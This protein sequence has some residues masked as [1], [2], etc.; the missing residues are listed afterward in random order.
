[1]SERGAVR[2]LGTKHPLGLALPAMFQDDSFVQRMCEGLDEVL[3]PVPAT[4][5]SFWAY[6]DPRLCPED[7]VDWLGSWLG[8]EPDQ[9]WSVERRRAL[10]ESAADLSRSVGTAAGLAD[11]I[12][13]Y[14]GSRPEITEGGGVAW[15]ETPDTPLPGQPNNRFVVHLEVDDP[16]TVDVARLDRM[17]RENKPA[18]LAHLVE[19]VKGTKRTT[20]GKAKG[21]AP[22][23]AVPPPPPPPPPPTPKVPPPPPP[24]PPSKEAE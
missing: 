9:N 15:S 14:T 19:V 1:M 22:E 6:L 10:V 13:L 5:D 12:E 20:T 2:G 7:F 21:A 4:L 18:H 3:A 16:S 17:V 11:A 23:D 8:L 24:P